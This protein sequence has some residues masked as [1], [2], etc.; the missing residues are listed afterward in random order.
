MTK[1]PTHPGEI[2]ASELDGLKMSA[3]ELARQI[4]VPANRVTQILACKRSV[5]AD[6]ALRL[7]KLLGTG[8]RLWLNLQQTYDLEVAEKKLGD[9]LNSIR[10]Q[11]T[12]LQK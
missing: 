1:T 11:K 3:A 7:G 9:G 2:L 4:K 10:T 5:T 8:P 12:A 6:T